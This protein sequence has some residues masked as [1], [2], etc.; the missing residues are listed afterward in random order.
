M[1][2]KLIAAALVTASLLG[3]NTTQAHALSLTESLAVM[4]VFSGNTVETVDCATLATS[5]NAL[6]FLNNNPTRYMLSNNIAGS[7]TALSQS[8]GYNLNS[9]VVTKL[10]SDVSYRASACGLTRPSEFEKI[11]SVVG[12][13][14]VL[15]Y[16][17][18]IYAVL[19]QLG[20]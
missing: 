10:A 14:Q 16:T 1:K 15:A 9:T 18:P 13:S 6:G 2:K 4:Q 3:F 7:A 20:Y 17:D 11:V 19:P 12:S 5:L 8:L